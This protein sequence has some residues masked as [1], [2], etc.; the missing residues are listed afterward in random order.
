MPMNPQDEAIRRL[1]ASFTE[2]FAEFAA[3]HERLHD[4]M[5]DLASE[6][7]CTNIP[8]VDEEAGFAVATELIMNTTIRPV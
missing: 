7:V 4:L 6:F 3:G 5:L 1:A 2:D 8:I